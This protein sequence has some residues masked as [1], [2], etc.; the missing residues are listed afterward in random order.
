MQRVVL[1]YAVMASLAG[2]EGEN[3]DPGVPNAEGTIQIDASTGT[4][5]F[6]FADEGVVTVANPSSS[7]AWRSRP[8]I[9]R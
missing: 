1:F 5:Y 7:T 6:S 3:N 2:C 8:S 9:A 4:A